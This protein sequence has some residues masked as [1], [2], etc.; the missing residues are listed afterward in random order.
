M[1]HAGEG[2]FVP[3][4]FCL[5]PVFVD[6]VDD[7]VTASV[8]AVASG[9]IAVAN[10]F[11]SVWIELGM[12]GKRGRLHLA[13]KVVAADCFESDWIHGEWWTVFLHCK[14]NTPPKDYVGI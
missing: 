9:L 3:A 13:V 10:H 2:C 7:D 11:S 14:K 6:R 12:C 1:D 5:L 8:V 4:L